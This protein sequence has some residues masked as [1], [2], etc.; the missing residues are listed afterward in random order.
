MF[1]FCIESSHARGMGHLFRS[2]TLATELRSR[3]QS[4]LFLA[5]DH[6]NSLKII[7]ERGFDVALYELAAVTGWEKD[8]LEAAAPSSIWINDR[9]NTQLSHSETITRLGAK[10]VTF[11]DR[12]DGAELA[13]INVCALLF[14]KT[15]GLKGK[16]VR[17]GV[18]YMILNPEIAAYRRVRQSL[19]SILVTLGGADTYGVTVRVAKWLSS[20]PFPVT[21]VTGPSFQHMAELEEVVATAAP[22]R[23]KLLN[24]VPSLAV[25]M[26]GHDLAI[27]GGGVTPFEACAAGLPCVVIANEPFEIPVGRALEELGAA[28]FAGHHS[29][30]DL[31]ILEK[32]IPIRTMSETAMTKVDLGGV[33]RVADL[34]ERL[35]A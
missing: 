28:F 8:F 24:Q 25:E 35:A 22:D 32:Q 20:K 4:V 3:G 10:L 1:V 14:E 12:G 17:L 7:R 21:I 29:A 26:H 15:E 6:P 33:G 19:A 27:T 30:F 34:L 11:D 16:D 31:G 5:N 9:L 13:D 2:L 23:F 18:E